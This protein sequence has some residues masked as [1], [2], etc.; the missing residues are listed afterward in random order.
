MKIKHKTVLVVEDSPVQ[1]ASIGQLLEQKGL[2]VLYA[3]DGRI[4]V[5]MAQQHKPD[6]VVL[7]LQMPAMD[8]FEVCKC[9]KGDVQTADIPI[10]ILTAHADTADA[11]VRGIDLGA[12]D[13]I[14]KDS[15][16]DTVLV[17]TLRQL[18]VLE[19]TREP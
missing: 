8:G 11:V 10:V 4:G 17:E 19:D 18:H 2:R 16:A 9:L 7:D 1:A 6:A 12:I 15:F 5:H 14:P 13:F 3:L